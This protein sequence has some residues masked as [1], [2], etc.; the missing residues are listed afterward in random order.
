M[1][2]D[3]IVGPLAVPFQIF[4]AHTEESVQ[5]DV[6]S[7]LTLLK[8]IPIIGVFLSFCKMVAHTALTV[9]KQIFVPKPNFS[10]LIF[11]V[12][13]CHTAVKCI[14]YSYLKII[15]KIKKKYYIFIFILIKSSKSTFVVRIS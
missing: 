13:N 6:Q 9:L 12:S 14:F 11:V 2:E 7:S 15:N 5:A 8:N 4:V 10:K 3:H 1:K